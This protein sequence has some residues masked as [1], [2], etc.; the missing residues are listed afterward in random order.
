MAANFAKLPDLWRLRAD[1]NRSSGNPT[2]AVP[3]SE[4]FV[5]IS[6]ALCSCLLKLFSD[7]LHP[8]PPSNVI[9]QWTPKAPRASISME[10]SAITAPVSSDPVPCRKCGTAMGLAAITPHPI[11]ASMQRHTFFCT[12]C[13]QTQTYMLPAT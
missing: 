9:G 12:T 5:S 13:N 6:G 3:N 1:E 7:G 11:V 10:A 2:G 8:M 4:A